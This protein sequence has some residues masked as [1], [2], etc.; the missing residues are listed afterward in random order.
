MSIPYDIKLQYIFNKLQPKFLK[1]YENAESPIF[2][3]NIIYNMKN[4]IG[5]INDEETLTNLK[6]KY[7]QEIYLSEI[8]IKDDD[9]SELNDIIDYILTH[10]E[11]NHVEELNDDDYNRLIPSELFVKMMKK[12]ININKSIDYV[13]ENNTITISE[14]LIINIHKQIGQNIID[15]SGNYRTRHTKPDGSLRAE[16]PYHLPKNIQQNLRILVNFTNDELNKIVNIK[17]KKLMMKQIIKLSTI[18]FSEFLLIHP[19]LNGN[20][21]VAH[22]LI[23]CIFNNVFQI[24]ISL[25][26]GTREKYIQV[27][28][29]RIDYI[30]DNKCCR[31]KPDYLYG[32]FIECI[33][34]HYSGL[35]TQF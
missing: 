5:K 28:E 12:C 6:Y 32:Y 4:E 22:L 20:G 15:N 31:N 13:M 2:D 25:Y 10:P 24:P 21:R 23:Q 1:I 11:L 9:H 35:I 16:S 14:E 27:L 3:V 8:N 26:S 30:D 19:F 34:R 33:F 18:L 17:N 29:K 7:L